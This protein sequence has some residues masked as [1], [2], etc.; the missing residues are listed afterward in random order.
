M[1]RNQRRMAAYNASKAAAQIE[2]TNFERR[3]ML[4]LSGCSSERVARAVSGPSVR[5]IKQE[6]G[7]MCLPE[8]AIFAA[9]HRKSE[10]V[11]AR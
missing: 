4:T 9:G 1:N 11:T 6:S 2:Q 10:S 5:E 7:A 8:V 3:I